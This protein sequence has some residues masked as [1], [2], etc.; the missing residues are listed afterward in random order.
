MTE[1][2]FGSAIYGGD[3]DFLR[4]CREGYEATSHSTSGLIAAV[5]RRCSGSG[6]EWFYFKTT[7]QDLTDTWLMLT[8]REARRI[9]IADLD[10]AITATEDLCAIGIRSW[11]GELTASRVCRSLSASRP[12]VGS[13]NCGGTVVVSTRPLSG[14]MSASFAVASAYIYRFYGVP[15]VYLMISI[16]SIQS[17]AF[18]TQ[19]TY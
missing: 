13:L 7:V 3:A 15:V 18:G 8:L 9:L 19:V 12:P 5:T 1:W 6:R 16:S 2:S 4:E 14:W 10:R 17:L 11:P